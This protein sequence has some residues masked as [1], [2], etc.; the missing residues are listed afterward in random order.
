MKEMTKVELVIPKGV[1]DFLTD[2]FKFS[3]EEQPLKEFLAEELVGSVKS[4]LQNLP[5]TLFD[6][7]KLLER[8]GLD[9]P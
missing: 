6:T 4:I 8:Y 1:I 5:N 2:L 3:G 9:K 7:D